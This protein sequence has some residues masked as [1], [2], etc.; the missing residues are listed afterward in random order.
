MPTQKATTDLAHS[1]CHESSPIVATASRTSSIITVVRDPDHAL[2]KQFHVNSD[3]SI[4]KSSKVH[5]SLGIAVQRYVH[6]HVEL[7]SLLNEVGDD[8]HAAIINASFAGVE[9]GEEFLILSESEIEKRLG[10]ASGDREHQQGVHSLEYCGKI[11]KAVGRFKQNVRPSNW[12]LLDRD[13][14]SHTPEK[15]G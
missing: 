9:I 5:L 7:V 11:Y 10:I 8:T 13:V 3:G 4:S 15:Y 1:T 2:G 12:Q 6:T 14:D